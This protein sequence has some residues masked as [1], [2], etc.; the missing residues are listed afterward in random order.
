MRSNNQTPQD[1]PCPPKGH[2][3][4]EKSMAKSSQYE[5]IESNNMGSPFF[6]NRNRIRIN[7]GKHQNEGSNFGFRLMK[8]GPETFNQRNRLK[9][10]EIGL[11]VRER[12]GGDGQSKI[13][14]HEH[15]HQIQMT[16]KL[17]GKRR[18]FSNQ[19]E[20]IDRTN[21]ALSGSDNSKKSKSANDQDIQTDQCILN[22]DKLRY[23]QVGNTNRLIPDIKTGIANLRSLRLT[24]SRSKRTRVLYEYPILRKIAECNAKLQLVKIFHT[25]STKWKRL[26]RAYL[27]KSFVMHLHLRQIKNIRELLRHRQNIYDAL[28]D[29]E[30][31]NNKVNFGN[32]LVKNFCKGLANFVIRFVDELVRDGLLSQSRKKA[33]K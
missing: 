28:E 30:I 12:F 24:L 5:D 20:N 33:K 22:Q 17:L 6:V 29:P 8:P 16:S 10:G 11:K 2:Q 27:E 21:Q 31:L 9:R 13:K 15:D 19:R 23:D 4:A 32:N 25:L 3:I 26:I 1:M 18:I 7:K 14:D